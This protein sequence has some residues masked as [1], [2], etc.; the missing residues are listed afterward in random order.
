M[1]TLL[2]YTFFVFTTG[3]LTFMLLAQPDRLSGPI[4]NTRMVALAGNVPPRARP[5]FDRGPVPASFPMPAVTIYL[6]PSASQQIVLQ[7]LLANQQNP[8]S[9]DYHKWLTPEQ[10]AARFGV[11]RSDINRIT[12][13]LKAQ[14]LQVRRVARSRTWVEFSGTAQQ[15]ENA[16]HTQIHQYLENGKLHYANSTNPSIPA[17]LSNMVLGVRGLNDYRLKPLNKL[18][19]VGPRNTTASGEHQMAPGD[20]AIIYDVAPL[21]AAGIDGTGQ[22]LVIVGQTDINVSDINA[23]RSMYSLPAINLQ[24]I[25]VPGRPTRASARAICRKPTWIWNGRARWHEM[26]TSFSYIPPMSSLRCRKPWI[27]PMLPSSA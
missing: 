20:F 11:S 18:R 8:A 2:R 10:Y 6:K 17:A 25:L 5:A 27:R 26:P 22:K 1:R 3:L 15:V 4:D 7:Q 9:A 21:Y 12:A 14:G 16:F 13:W 23:F 19:G 24:Q